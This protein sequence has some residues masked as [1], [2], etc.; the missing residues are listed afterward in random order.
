MVFDQRSG[1]NVHTRLGL[2]PPNSMINVT[3]LNGKKFFIN[4]ELIQLV[5]ATPDT[6]ITLVNHEKYIVKESTDE[7]VKK[8]IE[9]KSRLYHSK[10]SSSDQDTQVVAGAD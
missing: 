10:M 8:I 6:V 4:A 1:E 3:R 9:Y 5:E 2:L 7:V